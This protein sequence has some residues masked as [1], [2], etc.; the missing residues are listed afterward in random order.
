MDRMIA[1]VRNWFRM[2]RALA[3]M[4][5]L[6]PI[7]LVCSVTDTNIIFIMPMPPTISLIAAMLPNRIV[8]VQV[9]AWTVLSMSS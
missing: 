2:S 6:T 3:P 8:K 1:F 9:T 4:A 7:S 5:I